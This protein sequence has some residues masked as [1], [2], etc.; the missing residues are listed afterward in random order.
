VDSQKNVPGSDSDTCHDE[1]RVINIK[2]ED[3][4]D[5]QEDEYPV[6]VACPVIKDE[7]EVCLCVYC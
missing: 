1:N 4:T 7:Q 6:L 3:V 2:T 5:V